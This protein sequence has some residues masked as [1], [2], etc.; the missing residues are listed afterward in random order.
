MDGDGDADLVAGNMGLNT[1][2]RA[3]PDEPLELFLNDFDNNGRI[4]PILS[5]FQD[6][7]RYP[8]ANLDELNRQFNG[9]DRRYPTFASFAGQ[10]LE[11][12]FDP[13]LLKRSF[14]RTVHSLASTLFRNDGQGNF[15]ALPLP[16]PAQ[17]SAIRALVALPPDDGN[18]TPDILFCGN[19]LSARP[20]LGSQDASLGGI[21]SWEEGRIQARIPQ[22][23]G[24]MLR[25]DQRKIGWISL[26]GHR[27]LLVAQND[28]ILRCL[29]TEPE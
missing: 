29:S 9:L 23:T 24:L 12:V 6:G 21:L 5:Q 26:S 16:E 27:C 15:E 2:L 19:L 7:N 10:H 1:L 13:E 11:E 8:V 18:G 14:H 22:E 20:S 4:D 17:F 28:G 3:S 25:G